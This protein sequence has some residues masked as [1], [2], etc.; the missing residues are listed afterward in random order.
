[1]EKYPSPT[2]DLLTDR[3]R[4]T[5][6]LL[7]LH[8]E[9]NDFDKSKLDGSL[10]YMMG[11]MD[12]MCQND[13]DILRI[14]SELE[15]CVRW[16]RLRG[17]WLAY[18]FQQVTRK[19]GSVYHIA[20]SVL[21]SDSQLALGDDLG[22]HSLEVAE[23]AVRKVMENAKN[24]EDFREIESIIKMKMEFYSKFYKKWCKAFFYKEA[25]P[26]T[27]NLHTQSTWIDLYRAFPEIGISFLKVEPQS[28]LKVIEDCDGPDL[29]YYRILARK[30]L[31]LAYES[32]NRSDEAQRQFEIGLDEALKAKLES[33]IGHFHR[34]YGCALSRSKRLSE[35]VDQLEMAFKHEHMIFPYSLYWEALSA[36]ELASALLRLAL[37]KKSVEE[38]AMLFSRAIIAFQQ[39][40]MAFDA[41]RAISPA[42]QMALVVK[43]LLFRS[44]SEEAFNLIRPFANPNMPDI[45]IA[46]IAEAEAEGQIQA[47]DMV[48]ETDAARNMPPSERAAF[49]RGRETFQRRLNCIHPEIDAYWEAFPDDY[50]ARRQYVSQRLRLTKRIEKDLSSHEIARKILDLEP[51]DCILLLIHLG[52]SQ[53]HLLLI[54]LM[55]SRIMVVPS[56][57]THADAATISKDYRNA[58][59][60]AQSIPSSED[61][62]AAVQKAIGDLIRRYEVILGPSLSQV[63]DLIQGRHLVIV[64]KLQMNEVP[65]HALKVDGRYLL[66]HCRVSYCPT[67]GVFL[68]LHS[69]QHSDKSSIYVVRDANIIEFE[70]AFNALKNTSP[71]NMQI[72]EKTIWEE[73]KSAQRLSMA[74]DIIFAC[75]GRFDP[76]DPASSYI[77]LSDQETVSFSEIFSSI[78]LGDCRSVT[79]AACESGL[80]RTDLAEEYIGLPGAFLSAGAQNV[81]GSL[82]KVNR[83]ATSILLSKHLQIL[84]E[85]KH[86]V[87]E[88]LIESERQLMAMSNNDVIEWVEKYLKDYASALVPQ[89]QKMGKRPF[90]DPYFWAGFYASGGI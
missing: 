56:K 3:Q 70:G 16:R 1:M 31:G 77:R 25:N 67:L 7:I 53:S 21:F 40:L 33:E 43:R 34:L 79:L 8:M 84:N 26:L 39:G 72:E 74:T 17:H 50:E 90:E 9:Q 59:A 2:M 10:D 19:K 44:F 46:M 12:S 54:D 71:E 87:P 75:H 27:E 63:L 58:M 78:D 57:I 24:P 81:V 30:F 64:P 47:T 89:I 4:E 73:I 14:W 62:I 42:P 28:L 13:E 36:R 55:H 11:C 29:I 65:I 82:W 22:F 52:Q 88:A 41:S 76:M 85:R 66:E 15:R 86:T 23:S 83:L 68:K 49:R 32:R 5:M 45:M 20:S 6:K 48:S 18:V 61:R 69:R 38:R 51:V 60:N 35:A 80:S 37:T